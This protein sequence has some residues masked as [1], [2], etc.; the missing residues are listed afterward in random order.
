[1]HTVAIEEDLLRRAIANPVG[2]SAILQSD[3]VSF[4]AQRL[5][6]ILISIICCW[7]Q[8]TREQKLRSARGGAY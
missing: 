1:M 3:R 4:L 6:D 2:L 5:V 7:N 8:R